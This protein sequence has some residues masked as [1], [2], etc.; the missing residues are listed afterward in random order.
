MDSRSNLVT[1]FTECTQI[2]SEELQ[3]SYL[4][5]LPESIGSTCGIAQCAQ[6]TPICTHQAATPEPYESPPYRISRDGRNQ[7][8]SPDVT[9]LLESD[10][11]DSARDDDRLP[12]LADAYRSSSL[13]YCGCPAER[14]RRLAVQPY[15][16]HKG[17]VCKTV[18]IKVDE[19]QGLGHARQAP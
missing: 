11:A 17:A 13:A 9:A 18:P 15:G 1:G 19:C 8:L 10:T 3:V 2:N 14:F 12:W 16:P 7:R 6:I 5:K 4:N